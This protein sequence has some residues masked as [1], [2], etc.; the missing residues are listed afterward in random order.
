MEGHDLDAE[1]FVAPHPGQIAVSDIIPVRTLDLQFPC[2]SIARLKRLMCQQFPF[3]LLCRRK[4]CF[5]QS[6]QGFGSELVTDADDL[7]CGVVHNVSVCVRAMFSCVHRKW[8]LISSL[9]AFQRTTLFRPVA[10]SAADSSGKI[11]ILRQN[12]HRSGCRLKV[13]ARLST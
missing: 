6:L 9:F 10:R 13:L 3:Q 5:T 1:L 7:D 11:Y 4:E 2:Q 8:C 12:L